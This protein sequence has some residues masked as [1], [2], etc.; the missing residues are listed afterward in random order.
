MK[1]TLTLKAELHA[2]KLCHKKA[3]NMFLFHPAARTYGKVAACFGIK[4]QDE[5]FSTLPIESGKEL[6]HFYENLQQQIKDKKV[7]RQKQN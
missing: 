5:S 6:L 3:L 2:L 7:L 4:I 1:K